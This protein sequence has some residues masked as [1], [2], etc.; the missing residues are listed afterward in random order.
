MYSQNSDY[1][2][3]P[4]LKDIISN[5]I[6]NKNQLTKQHSDCLNCLI[7]CTQY[8]F[9]L[10]VIRDP[11]K[12][13]NN[14]FF[15]MEGDNVSSPLFF[16]K[17]PSNEIVEKIE[18]KNL[19]ENLLNNSQKIKSENDIIN[20]YEQNKKNQILL[21]NY[22]NFP[23]ININYDNN[24]NKETT[25]IILDDGKYDTISTCSIK[26]YSSINK[27]YSLLFDIHNLKNAK[28]L[29]S[30]NDIKEAKEIKFKFNGN[31]HGKQ[32][33]KNDALC[34]LSQELIINSIKKR[35]EKY[36]NLSDNEIRNNLYNK[37]F[38]KK[39]IDNNRNN[40][41]ILFSFNIKK[42]ING[43]KLDKDFII[44]HNYLINKIF[45]CIDMWINSNNYHETKDTSK[46]SSKISNS[47]QEYYEENNNNINYN[48]NC[49]TN[50]NNYNTNC[51]DKTYKNYN[52]NN[53]YTNK[54]NNYNYLYNN[55]FY[56][57]TEYNS[58]YNEYNNNNMEYNN[59][60]NYYYN[61][62]NNDYINNNNNYNINDKFN[63]KKNNSY[64][65]FYK[66]FNKS[67]YLTNENKNKYSENHSSFSTNPN[68][69]DSFWQK[70]K[71]I[72]DNKYTSSETT[73]SNQ[74]IFD[75]K[76][77]STNLSLQKSNHFENMEF[78]ENCTLEEYYELNILLNN[79]KDGKTPYII[80]SKKEVEVKNINENKDENKTNR[81]FLN[82]N[83]I[84]EIF[85]K[86][87]QNDCISNFS[88]LKK[89]I[90]INMNIS[91]E[92]LK[93]IKLKYFF[94][95][96][97]DINYLSLNIP[98]INKKGQLLINELNPTLSSMRLVLKV[99]KNIAKKIKK[100]K[101]EKFVIKIIKE[102]LIKIEYEEI[103]PPHE[104]DLLYKKIDE[105]KQILG[106]NKLT[107]KNVLFDKS[108][109]CILW[110]FTN[111]NIINSSF[112][113]Y[114]SFNFKLIGIFII[115]LNY[116]QWLSSFSYD[117]NKFHDYQNEYNK[118]IEELKEF[119]KNLPIDKDDGYYQNFYTHDYMQYIQISK[120]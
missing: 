43:I 109:F 20:D 72:I 107:F 34:S 102:N 31:I 5:V 118:N 64:K 17:F 74:N 120:I 105:I 58:N 37:Y 111:S 117:I 77:S 33:F 11:K 27:N 18:N 91:N 95:C 26:S 99:R 15:I 49:T 41:G 45:M 67:S 59:N 71:T 114:Y 38:F 86:Y 40:I 29:F 104:R 92:K 52:Y 60:Y 73:P 48:M 57:N 116:K 46:S 39:L 80:N 28:Y 8:R 89:R 25:I 23:L 101:K 106:D 90:D 9:I 115:K 10:Q 66:T 84:K 1:G 108:Y 2:I 44:K 53:N 4:E 75:N 63:D 112:L 119:F 6:K 96:F 85:F 12:G 56:N 42:N 103:K 14:L 70:S 35:M 113:A 21:F 69:Y 81:I 50:Y 16:Y 93:K 51:Y 88:I 98:Y 54:Y 47:K 30:L 19:S 3:K 110:S 32:L 82:I 7:N 100:Q 22:L 76:N 97:K 83:F 68:K 13:K 61:R 78:L 62:N 24:I 65:T 87:K 94:D 79:L 55:N 36:I